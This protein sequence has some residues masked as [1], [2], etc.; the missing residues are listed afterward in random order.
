[1][2]SSPFQER[3]NISDPFQTPCSNHQL[4]K[5]PSNTG[6]Q[7][8]FRFKPTWGSVGP[9]EPQLSTLSSSQQGPETN[10]ADETG[11]FVRRQSSF[12]LR[13]ELQTLRE[14][15]Q[16]GLI[17]HEQE[18]RSLET[19]LEDHAKRIDTVE[20]EKR[21][22]FD[23]EDEIKAT[24]KKSTEIAKSRKQELERQIR[25]LKSENSEFKD[26][27][28]DKQ[29]EID[30]ERREN[31]R[32]FD[33][34]ESRI[35]AEVRMKAGLQNELQSITKTLHDVQ[36]K[37]VNKDAEVQDLETQ[38]L[39]VKTQTGDIETLKLLQKELSGCSHKITREH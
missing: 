9:I 20:A 21:F 2:D 25:R 37:L 28:N 6:T 23:K 10:T 30:S 35:Q 32:R 33:E 14:E 8:N 19:K 36:S 7:T 29:D 17:R 11:V 34:Y 3:P 13:Y 24:L 4:A 26:L 16:L 5:S 15:R 12:I 31:R 22:L 1:M 39:K 38:L 27:I 18:I